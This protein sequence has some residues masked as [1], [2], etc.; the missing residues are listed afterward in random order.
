MDLNAENAAIVA[1]IL[2]THVL[3]VIYELYIHPLW[4]RGTEEAVTVT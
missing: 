2:S 4:F 3:G 1:A